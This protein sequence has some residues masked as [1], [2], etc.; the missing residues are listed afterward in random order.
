MGAPDLE[1]LRRIAAE[2][3]YPSE[4][5]A[6]VLVEDLGAAAS[7]GEAVHARWHGS[8]EASIDDF[9]AA[10]TRGGFASAFP[11]N[12]AG[13]AALRTALEDEVGPLAAFVTGPG[14]V[15]THL[16]AGRHPGSGRVI[17]V[18]TTVIAT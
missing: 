7:V 9:F 18:V 12:A 1:R 16:V 14:G 8:G 2:L 4:E 5:D 17:A 6:P 10:P 13:F 15:E 11:E 3:F